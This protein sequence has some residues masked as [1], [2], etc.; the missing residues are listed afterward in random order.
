MLKRG[1]E[2]FRGR[3]GLGSNSVEGTCLTRLELKVP[4]QQGRE[5]K[6]KK[7]IERFEAWHGAVCL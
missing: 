7:R 3:S 2:G 1:T 6:K 5:R 4:S